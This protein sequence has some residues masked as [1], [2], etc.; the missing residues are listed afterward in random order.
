MKLRQSTESKS[1]TKDKGRG[2]ARFECKKNDIVRKNKNK[3]HN[4]QKN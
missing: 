2:A 4:K 3:K 1:F